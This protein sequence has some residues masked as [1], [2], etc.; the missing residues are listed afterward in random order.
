MAEILAAYLAANPGGDF[1]AYEKA[2][3]G[4]VAY[5]A[6]AALYLQEQTDDKAQMDAEKS[7]RDGEVDAADNTINGESTAKD[8]AFTNATP[9]SA[10]TTAKT[11]LET[12][13]G[14]IQTAYETYLDLQ[15]KIWK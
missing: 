1:W 3:T 8:T 2:R 7:R 14:T 6:L 10:W 4:T 5:A 13:M 9:D 11:D 15:K 12:E